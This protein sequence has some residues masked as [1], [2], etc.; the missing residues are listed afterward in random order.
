M[1]H[2]LYI[3]IIMCEFMSQTPKI[4]HYNLKYLICLQLL[5]DA[6]ARQ[7][8][9][10][11]IVLLA[12]STPEDVSSAYSNTDRRTPLHIAAQQGNAI[13]LQ[14][15]L[16]VSSTSITNIQQFLDDMLHPNLLFKFF[17]VWQL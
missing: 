12:N 11:V 2:T 9:S 15:L 3:I 6:I 14:L 4:H 8:L 16:W 5:I 13:F 17:K 10:Q 7:E 1:Q